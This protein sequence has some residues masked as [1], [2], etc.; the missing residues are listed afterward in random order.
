MSENGKAKIMGLDAKGFVKY[1]SGD[2]KASVMGNT[3]NSSGL[4]KVSSKG[5]HPKIAARAK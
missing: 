2:P 1:A 3:Y 4:E 5:K